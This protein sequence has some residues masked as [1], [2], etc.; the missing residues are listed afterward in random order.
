MPFIHVEILEG[1]TE[2]QKQEIVEEVTSS[3]QRVAKVPQDKVFIFFEDLTK[4]NY[5]KN[6]SLVSR[7]QDKNL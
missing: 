1:L 5:A 4:S 6:G 7:L 3:F 2:D